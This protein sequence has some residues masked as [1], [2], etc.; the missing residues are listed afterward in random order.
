[1]D[2]PL[3][4]I[5]P[6]PQLPNNNLPTLSTSH[7]SQKKKKK[8]SLANVWISKTSEE[9]PIKINSPRPIH[10]SSLDPFSCRFDLLKGKEEA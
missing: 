6:I 1:M 5:F 10:Q 2:F 7:F 4:E 8:E 3:K 9:I